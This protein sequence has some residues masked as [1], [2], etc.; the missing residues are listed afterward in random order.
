M[1]RR[2]SEIAISKLFG[3]GI[4]ADIAGRGTVYLA[5]EARKALAGE[6]ERL[7]RVRLRAGESYTV[8]A[9]PPATRRERKLA[10]RQGDLKQRERRASRPGRRQ[11]RAARRLERTQI[12]LDRA[13]PGSRKELK[14]EAKERR[15]G[16]RFDR[17]TTPT[18]RQAKLRGELHDVTERLDTERAE[19]F[20]AARRRRRSD[21]RTGERRTRVKVYD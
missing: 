6:D 21:R 19:S 20:A 12:K 16:E 9:R 5:D 15:R 17:V 4:G 14:L 7:T 10:A 18:R 3:D 8:I 11:F 13:R 2:L 1:L